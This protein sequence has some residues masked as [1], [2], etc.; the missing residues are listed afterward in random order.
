[1]NEAAM[2]I[3]IGGTQIKAVVVDRLGAVQRRELRPTEGNVD[4]AAMVRLLAK[5]LGPDL[6]VGISAPGLVQRDRRS[7]AC[8]PGRLQGLEGLDWTAWLKSRLPVWVCNDAHAALLGEKWI[9]AAQPFQNVFMLTLGTGVGGAILIDGELYRGNIGRAG[10]LGHV[11]LDH[12]SKELSITG[13]PGALECFLGNYNIRERTNGRFETT[14]ALIEAHRAG[15]AE[16]SRVWSASIHSLACALAS[17]INILDPEAIVIGGGIAQAGKALFDPLAEEL[18]KIEWR[19]LG[20]RVEVLPAQLG[21][22]AGAIGVAADAF[23][24]QAED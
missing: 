21:E 20:Q 23:K 1:M 11:C 4:F 5:E 2:G 6:P 13:M 19:P 18:Q 22:W 17:F 8:M 14:H 10:H 24:R 12:Q 16:A 7:V 3:D 15:D 9:G